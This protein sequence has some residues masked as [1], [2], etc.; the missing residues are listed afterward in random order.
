MTGTHPLQHLEAVL[1]I[2]IGGFA[3]SNLRHFVDLLL[4]TSLGATLTVN[5]LG[6]F[7]LGFF[8]YEKLYQNTI[9]ASSRNV[10]A[11]GFISSF[12]TYS[13]FLVE[14]ITTAPAVAVGYVIVSYGLG[15][16][17]VLVGR[18]GARWL[19]GPVSEEQVNS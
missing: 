10:L 18:Q 14:T 11:T 1:I 9:S 4:P 8:L 7:A 17:A 3:G 5:I 12:T 6:C 13:T 2:G 16:I 19:T 15:F